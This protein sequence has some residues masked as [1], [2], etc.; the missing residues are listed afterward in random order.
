MLRIAV[1]RSCCIFTLIS[2]A[3]C[4]NRFDS[5]ATYRQRNP[6]E[7]P[8][9]RLERPKYESTGRC[10]SQCRLSWRSSR[11]SLSETISASVFD[12]EHRKVDTASAFSLIGILSK[13]FT[14]FKRR[15]GRSAVLHKSEL[16][17]FASFAITFLRAIP[18]PML[19]FR[20]R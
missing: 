11:Y 8:V 13:R 18:L 19:W 15:R 16:R 14:I 6:F 2:L 10:C 9:N 5:A 20:V 1:F 4:A 3:L 7:C 17:G 12:E